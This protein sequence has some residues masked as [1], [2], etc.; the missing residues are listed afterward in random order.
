MISGLLLTEGDVKG[1]GNVEMRSNV[2]ANKR[3]SLDVIVK[4]A[5]EVQYEI[6]TA[7]MSNNEKWLILKKTNML[8]L[9]AI[10]KR[11]YLPD[12]PFAETDW[13]YWGA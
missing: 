11:E 13:L 8:I 4:R 6:V 7:L 10:V 5:S 9:K 3:M 1:A 12:N 2:G